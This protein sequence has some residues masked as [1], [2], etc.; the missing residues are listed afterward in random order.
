[1]GWFRVW[2]R[3]EYG[4]YGRCIDC[5]FGDRDPGGNYCYFSDYSLCEIELK[6]NSYPMANRW[7]MRF[8][9]DGKRCMTNVT[10]EQPTVGRC[11][12]AREKWRPIVKLKLMQLEMC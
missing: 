7:R 8:S 12:S 3:V 1:M 4:A 9:R 6:A 5:L 11:A 10:R 2:R